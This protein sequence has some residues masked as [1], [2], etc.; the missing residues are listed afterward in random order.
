MPS[1]EYMIKK[2]AAKADESYEQQQQQEQQ[3]QPQSRR[4]YADRLLKMMLLK[5]M[6]AERYITEVKN[7]NVA[8]PDCVKQNC[9]KRRSYVKQ[10]NTIK[11]DYVFHN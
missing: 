6:E 9:V 3:Q 11:N 10:K 7:L 4:N 1:Y 2:A 5:E 8:I